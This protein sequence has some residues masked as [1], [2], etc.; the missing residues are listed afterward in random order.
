MSSDNR[1]EL[2][3]DRRGANEVLVKSLDAL[4]VA[5]G[6]NNKNTTMAM[7]AVEKLTVKV[8]DL[9]TTEQV[10]MEKDR[11]QNIKNNKYDKF[12]EENRETLSTAKKHFAGLDKWKWGLFAMATVVIL[13][14]AGI[15]LK[16]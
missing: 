12:I 9:V 14:A 11:N 15:S 5:V 16:I 1:E 10:R 2:T 8:S 4:I 6:E 3:I 13:N 7:V